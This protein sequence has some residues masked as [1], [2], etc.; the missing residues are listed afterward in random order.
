M[1]KNPFK[2]ALATYRQIVAATIVFSAAINILMFV[3]PLYMLQVYDRVLQSRSEVTLLML[4]IIAVA[5]LALYGILEWLRSRVL[6]RAGLRFD[7][8]ISDGVFTRVVDT[9][10]KNP[11]SKSKFALMDIDRLREFLTGSGLISLCDLPWLPV[12]LAVCFFFHPLI[13]WIA[14]GGAIVIVIITI[15]NE[16]M[17]KTQL[18]EAT[19]VGQA[20]MHFSNSTL[21]N[22]EVIRALGM[23]SS[24]R[25]RWV[26]LHRS[27]LEKQAT[28][29]DRAGALQSFSKFVRM[30]L[31]TLILGAGAYLALQGQISPGSIIAASIMMG[32]ALQ[33]VD[34]VVAQWKQFIAARQAYDRLE[35]MFVEVPEEEDKIDLPTP[36]GK[37]SVENLILFAPGT[38]TPLVRGVS[39]EAQ[40]GEAVA[41]VGPSGAGKSSLVR[42]LVGIWAPASGSVRLDGAELQHWETDKLGQHVG[43]LPQSVELF[44]GTISENIARFRDDATSEEIINAAK[45]A[46]VH[47]LIQSMEKGYDT[48]IGPGGQQLSGGQRQRVGLARALF[49]NPALLVLDEPNANLDSEGEEALNKVILSLKAR[50]KTILFVSHKISLIAVS[51]KALILRDGAM[52]GFGATQDLLQPKPA[53]QAP[54]V[55]E[56]KSADENKTA[57]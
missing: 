39:F 2:Q 57:S 32:R 43:Y 41:V 12:F 45:Q 4:T 51:D 37:L 21:V 17:T 47:D 50:G 54:K 23:E 5:M 35:T 7:R 42:A 6:V 28:A 29:S 13:G 48:Q 56:A 16:F 11:Q 27:M 52:S 14:T 49:G 46:N 8:M 1:I 19:N 3:S 33:P 26:G 18:S 24:L 22:V 36:E 38:Q 9:S 55:E 44:E 30:G 40:P 10:I 31:Q 53:A 20:A 25:K 34:Q 15:A